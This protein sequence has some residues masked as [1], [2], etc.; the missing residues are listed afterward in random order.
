MKKKKEKQPLNKLSTWDRVKRQLPFWVMLVIPIAKFL[1]FN[2]FPLFGI[3]I[4]FQDYKLGD[5]FI[6]PES[7]WVGFKWFQ[8]F[9]KNPFAWR[10]IRNTLAISLRSIV[11]SFPMGIIIALIFNEI[12]NLRFRNLVNSVSLL[13]HFISTV[14]I[15]AMLKT[16]FSV[17]G[18][19]VNQ[20]L[21]ALGKQPINFMVSKDWY[22]TLY[23]GSGIWAGAGF[24]SLVYTAAISGIDPGLYEAARMDGA[25]R[26]KC[27][28]RITVPCIAPTV[29]TMFILRLGNILSVGYEKALLMYSP[30]IYEVSDMIST[31]SYRV[32]IMEGKSSLSTAIG[33]MDSVVN[34]V[35]LVTANKVSR[36]ISETS[37]W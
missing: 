19:I 11:F 14:V 13:P 33:L 20:A 18:G 37:L 16:M 5:P 21:V 31:Y 9:F 34:L 10:Y 1:L 4:A 17:D 3:A 23:I 12:T 36:K 26:W 35:V 30:A 29:I 2:Y 24:S 15:V 27:M 6:S 28:L 25:N 7:R 8:M 22:Y 32:G